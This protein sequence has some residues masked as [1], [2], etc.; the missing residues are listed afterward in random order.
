MDHGEPMCDTEAAMARSRWNEE[1]G[2]TLQLASAHADER[3]DARFVRIAVVRRAGLLSRW[4]NVQEMRAE[5]APHELDRSPHGVGDG[6]LLSWRWLSR[7]EA[8]ELLGHRLETLQSLGYAIIDRSEQPRGEWDWLRELVRQQLTP[9]EAGAGGSTQARAEALSDSLERLGMEPASIER[10]VAEL[11]SL[12]AAALR[13]PD[14]ATVAA[15]DASQL[16][17]LLPFLTAHR[18]DG[19]REI[20]DAWL[21]LPTTAYELDPN[22]VTSWLGDD[23]PLARA[24]VSRLEREGLALLGPDRLRRLSREARRDDVRSAASQWSA[25]MG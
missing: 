21:A 3:S 14:A 24:L 9:A 4:F 13:S 20:G 16:G 7:R 8:D 15:C 1:R 17:V 12:D 25:R 11:L 5:A 2:L 6:R 10:G 19:L 18:D 22:L 23:G